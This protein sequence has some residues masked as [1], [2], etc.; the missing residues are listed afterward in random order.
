M[1]VF[2]VRLLNNLMFLAGIADIDKNRVEAIAKNMGLKH[3]L[4]IKN[5]LV[6]AWM[7]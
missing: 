6:A 1:H 4:I 3:I 7:R 2:T 5:S